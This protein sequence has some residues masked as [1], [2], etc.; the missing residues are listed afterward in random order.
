MEIFP[1]IRPPSQAL[2]LMKSILAGD[3]DAFDLE[4]LNS[5][6]RILMV[7]LI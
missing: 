6:Q 7:R 1:N 5:F 3:S 2:S 4:W